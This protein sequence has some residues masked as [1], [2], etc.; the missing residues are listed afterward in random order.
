MNMHKITPEEQQK[1][2]YEKARAEQDRYIDDLLKKPPQEIVDSA[3][4]KVVREDI[5]VIFE[6]EDL[7]DKQVKELLKLKYP[8]AECYD[9]WLKADC[10]HMDMLRDTIEDFGESLVKNAELKKKKHEPER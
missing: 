8:L 2:L 3:Y 5:L 7:P 10:S 9:K 4:E 1:R 6:S